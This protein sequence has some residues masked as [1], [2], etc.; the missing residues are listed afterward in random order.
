MPTCSAGQAINR[1]VG[2]INPLVCKT[3]RPRTLISKNQ[4]F[5]FANRSGRIWHAACLH[6]ERLRNKPSQRWEMAQSNQSTR[7]WQAARFRS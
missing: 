2:I 7:H 3:A 1:L 5:T 6:A 4:S